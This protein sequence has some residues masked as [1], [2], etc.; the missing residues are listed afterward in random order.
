MPSVKYK[1][2]TTGNMLPVSVKVGDTLP[3]GTE[4][5]YDGD[6]VPL[7]YEQV[8]DGDLIVSSS[9]PSGNDRRKVWLR[10]S[11]NLYNKNNS[12]VTGGNNQNCGNKIYLEPSTTYTFS[13]GTYTWGTIYLYNSANTSN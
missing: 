12:Y 7:G 10:H 4:L 3:V 5:D 11:E 1:D 13:I 6:T 8:A 9:E 2:S